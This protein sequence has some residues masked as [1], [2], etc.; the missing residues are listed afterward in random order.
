MS[1]R[2]TNAIVLKTYDYGETSCILHLFSQEFG[3]VRGI[4]KGIKG[5]KGCAVPERGCIINALAYVRPHRELHTLGDLS[6]SRVYP[7]I[8]SDLLKTAMRDMVFEIIIKS[9]LHTEANQQLFVAIGTF[10][11]ELEQCSSTQRFPFAVWDF[12][13]TFAGMQGFAIDFDTCVV[14]QKPLGAD[15]GGELRYSVGGCACDGCATKSPRY[16]PSP[17]L[18]YVAR[19]AEASKQGP[20]LSPSALRAITRSLVGYCSYHFDIATDF[21]ALPFLEELIT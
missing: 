3:S 18:A 20:K 19:S 16:L 10:L 12:V 2:K 21:Q 6:L 8:R 7:S 11:E 14:C 4:A 15:S 13:V 9:V 17:A 5:R 1:P